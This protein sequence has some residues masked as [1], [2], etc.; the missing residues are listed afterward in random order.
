MLLSLSLSLSLSLAR[1]QDTWFYIQFVYISVHKWV[2]SMYSNRYASTKAKQLIA[3]THHCTILTIMIELRCLPRLM[4]Y[5]ESC[6]FLSVWR[7]VL[8][9]LNCWKND[10]L[11]LSSSFHQMNDSPQ[12]ERFLNRKYNAAM[13]IGQ[14]F[15]YSW[16]TRTI[17]IF[18][19]CA[20]LIST[21]VDASYDA[22][23]V[24]STYV[25][26]DIRGP[27][28]TKVARRTFETWILAALVTQMSG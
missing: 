18:Q 2:R 7:N 6:T 26:I 25:P 1:A 3:R 17:S 16:S 12:L 14:A 13:I 9:N 4:R 15:I 5:K 10:R 8:D 27:S 19:I 20:T 23:F 28:R 24:S 21:D 22:T 11:I